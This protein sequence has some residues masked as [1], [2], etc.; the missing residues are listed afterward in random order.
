MQ[1]AYSLLQMLGIESADL[2]RPGASIHGIPVPVPE[3]AFERLMGRMDLH[4]VVR[5]LRLIR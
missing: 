4:G 3:G 5:Q 1:S 2:V